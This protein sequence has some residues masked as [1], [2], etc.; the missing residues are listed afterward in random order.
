MSFSFC[1]TWQLIKSPNHSELVFWVSLF[2]T[3]FYRWG[4]RAWQD[5]REV[6][7]IHPGPQKSGSATVTACL[8][9]TPH[10]ITRQTS[11]RSLSSCV[12]QLLHPYCCRGSCTA[13]V[14]ALPKRKQELLE[15]AGLRNLSIINLE[16]LT[17]GTVQP[18][19]SQQPHSLSPAPKSE[20]SRKPRG[21]SWFWGGGQNKGRKGAGTSKFCSWWKYFS[22]SRS[23]LALCF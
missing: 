16:N 20:A 19:A 6:T 22:M 11:S 13:P 14:P 7:R 4:F 5:L 21:H 3:F 9:L 23:N 15:V 18:D 17:K 10:P 12:P 1:L 8:L 2:L